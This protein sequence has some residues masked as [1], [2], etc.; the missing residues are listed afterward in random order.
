MHRL[1]IRGLL[2]PA[3]LLVLTSISAAQMQIPEKFTNLQVFPK[4]IPHDDLIQTMR[5][6]SFSLG[7]R[8]THCHVEQGEKMDF[9][10]DA[11]K[12]KD[13]ART[14][15]KMVGNINHE[16]IDKLGK[17][18]PTQVQCVTCHHGLARPRT[19]NAVMADT[20]ERKDLSAAIAE[21]KDLRKQYYGSGAYDFSETPLNIL[22]E[23][24]LKQKKNRNAVAVM[25][26]NVEYNTSPS[27]WTS[28]LLAMAHIANG[29]S[30]KAKADLD[31]ILQ[32]NPNDKWAK[33]QKEQLKK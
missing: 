19:I 30:D 9:A 31:K 28:H 17:E 16:Y 32:A 1:M 3:L 2:A 12:E 23:A 13:V 21:Y 25:E 11:K 18:S 20:M 14:M 4:D 24:L 7:V 27:G 15:L 5:G 8:C 22:T 10:S 33:E 29:D 6:F 26:M